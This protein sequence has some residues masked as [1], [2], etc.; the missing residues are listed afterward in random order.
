MTID[1]N[2]TKPVTGFEPGMFGENKNDET[3]SKL[4]K[5]IL[6]I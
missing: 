3:K 2:E 5:V 1:A 4:D 6:L